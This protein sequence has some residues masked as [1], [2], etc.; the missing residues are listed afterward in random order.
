MESA[1]VD[2]GAGIARDRNDRW[3][4]VVEGVGLVAVS[5][6]QGGVEHVADRVHDV[7]T[8][9]EGQAHLAVVVRKRAAAYGDEVLRVVA[10][11][12]GGA[13]GRRGRGAG[14]GEVCGVYQLHVLAEGHPE[15][16]RVGIGEPAGVVARAVVALDRHD[17]RR[18]GV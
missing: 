4:R 7:M 3:R 8:R 2:A 14:Y 18:G 16:Q 13:G 10:G 5:G 17:R 6:G 1:G 15:G 9:G 12:G 11:D